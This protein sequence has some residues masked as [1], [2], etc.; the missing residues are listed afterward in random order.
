MSSCDE[1]FEEYYRDCID[2]SN[3]KIIDVSFCGLAKKPYKRV[4]CQTAL[5]PECPSKKLKILSATL[6][7]LVVSDKHIGIS[8]L[9]SN[10]EDKSVYKICSLFPFSVHNRGGFSTS[11]IPSIFD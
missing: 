6:F 4:L 5:L 7:K 3:D 10:N 1:D 9:H 2:V 8:E 11:K